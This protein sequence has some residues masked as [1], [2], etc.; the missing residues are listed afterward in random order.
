MSAH[1]EEE[2]TRE[3]GKDGEGEGER[4]ELREGMEGRWRR[5]GM[6]GRWRREGMEGR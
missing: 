3:R 2:G 1:T 4:K 5:E 6:E